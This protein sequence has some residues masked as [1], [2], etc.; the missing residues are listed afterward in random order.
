MKSE[1]PS[2]E[3]CL[4]RFDG[5]G[6]QLRHKKDLLDT[7]LGAKLDAREVWIVLTSS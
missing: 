6:S 1:A 4:G 7:R 5:P 2:G 3:R